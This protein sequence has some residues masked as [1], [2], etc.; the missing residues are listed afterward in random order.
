[1]HKFLCFLGLAVGLSRTL[2]ADLMSSVVSLASGS[3]ARRCDAPGLDTTSLF[4]RFALP[5]VVLYLALGALFYSVTE[6]W[7]FTDGLYFCAV[8]ITTVGYGD[9]VPSSDA[10]K[11]FTVAYILIGLSLVATAS[12]ELFSALGSVV[13][14]PRGTPGRH[15]R[16]AGFAAATVVLII[17]VGAAWV[18][19]MEGW[20]LLD[21]VYWAVVTC[22][23]VGYGDLAAAEPLTRALLAPYIV[24]GVGGFAV[25]LARFGQVCMEIE[26]DKA[27][28]TFIARGVTEPMIAEMC[29]DGYSRYTGGDGVDRTEFLTYMLVQMGQVQRG[30]VAKVLRLFDALDADGSGRIDA[31]DIRAQQ[32]GAMLVTATPVKGPTRKQR[33]ATPRSL[34]KLKELVKPLLG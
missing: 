17:L 25:S 8:T 12:G 2:S 29:A 24:A 28:D 31:G 21:S 9:F 11:A 1:M 6:G 18:M 14:V 7:S 5:I 32:A 16:Q 23:S 13:E 22:G 30:D 33:E 15:L 34:E 26:A 27:I 10:S 19:W 3:S 4:S 20:G